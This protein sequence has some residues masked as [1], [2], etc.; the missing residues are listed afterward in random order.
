VLGGRK[1]M[2]AW[3]RVAFFACG[4]I[5][6]LPVSELVEKYESSCDYFFIPL[7]IVYM[8]IAIFWP[9]KKDD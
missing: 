6:A 5:L 2:K 3:R 1:P 7:G 4:A 9:N 8:L